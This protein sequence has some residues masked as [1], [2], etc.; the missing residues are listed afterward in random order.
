MN[1]RREQAAPVRSSVAHS[2][3]GIA[4][5]QSRR[6]ISIMDGKKIKGLRQESEGGKVAGLSEVRQ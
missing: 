5:A 3:L 4:P 1:T 6:L 2:E